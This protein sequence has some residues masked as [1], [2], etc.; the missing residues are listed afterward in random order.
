MERS[1]SVH[2]IAAVLDTNMPTVRKVLERLD[3]PADD[4][5]EKV[6]HSAVNRFVQGFPVEVTDAEFLIAVQICVGRDMTLIDVDRLHGW[7]RK[8]AENWVNRLRKRYQRAGREFPSL[9]RPSV[10]TFSEREVLAMREKSHA[11]A[12]DLELSMQFDCNRETVRSIV[13]GKRY[14]QYGGPIRAARSTRGLKASRNHMCGHGDNSLAAR[15][16]HEMGAAA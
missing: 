2:E 12:T 9:V 8:T 10:R 3:Q 7:E 6:D 14:P 1:A 11:G 15:T 13:T 16:K 5:T 4:S